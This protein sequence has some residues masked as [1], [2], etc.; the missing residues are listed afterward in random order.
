MLV[1]TC[2]L[3]MVV[4]TVT[5]HV[6]NSASYIELS[7]IQ[8]RK[9]KQIT[10]LS[11]AAESRRLTFDQLMQE[12]FIEDTRSLEE[13]VIDS[14]YAGLIQAMIDQRDRVIYILDFLSRDIRPQD[15]SSLIS[16]LE[17]W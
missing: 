9:L 17:S 11:L 12:L 4:L 10:L 2:S 14:I 13:I 15:V 16:R 5:L 8:I 6:E 1:L 3:L 7:D